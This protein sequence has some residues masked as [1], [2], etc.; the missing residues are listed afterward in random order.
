MYVNKSLFCPG[1]EKHHIP[2][3]MLVSL[4]DLEDTQK[5]QT[6]QAIEVLGNKA[7][8]QPLNPPTYA[9]KQSIPPSVQYSNNTGLSSSHNLI[10][11]G[12]TQ[13]PLQHEHKMYSKSASTIL[14]QQSENILDH[15]NTVP[16]QC[17]T[18]Q[19]HHFRDSNNSPKPNSPTEINGQESIS[20]QQ[21][22]PIIHL[23]ALEDMNQAQ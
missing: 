15:L 14:T 6:M 4:Q 3:D 1:K 19:S 2:E 9:V 17:H 16:S 23:P 12:A 21:I 18:V 5:P 13:M 8:A 11:N 20:N 7:P 22:R 10:P